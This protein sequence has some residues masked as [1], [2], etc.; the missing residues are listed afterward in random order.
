MPGAIDKWIFATDHEFSVRPDGLPELLKLYGFEFDEVRIM[1]LR[2]T[3]GA[4]KDGQVA[5]AM[6]FATDGRIAAF[7]L[8]SLEDNKK[9]FPVYN[10]TPVLRKEV[11]DRYPELEEILGRISPL[12]D[13]ETMINWNAQVDVENRIRRGVCGRG[14]G[15]S[16]GH[17]P[18]QGRALLLSHL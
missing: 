13:T 10:P 5:A 9:F 17:P 11:L 7:D 2:V 8:V 4:L 3:Y 18:F 16:R 1:D 12:L 15:N 6:G 14:S